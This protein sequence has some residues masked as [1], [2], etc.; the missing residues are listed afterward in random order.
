M[1]KSSRGDRE[2]KQAAAL[3]FEAQL[4]EKD[5]SL[6]TRLLRIER[7]GGFLAIASVEKVIV[8]RESVSELT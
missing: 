2:L 4:L 1:L 8:S 3:A 5:R 6:L 7:L